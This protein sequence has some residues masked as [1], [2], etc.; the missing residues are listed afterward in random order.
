L[1]KSKE[2]WMIKNYCV[3]YGIRSTYDPANYFE[4]LHEP[5][6]VN[7]TRLFDYYFKHLSNVKVTN[8]GFDSTYYHTA[9]DQADRGYTIGEAI[10]ALDIT[11]FD[12]YAEQKKCLEQII[13]KCF[14]KNIRVIL[15]TPPVYKTF[16]TPSDTLELNTSIRTCQLMQSGYSNVAYFNLLN[17]SSFTGN[18]YFDRSHLNDAGA[19]KLSL[20]MNG[21][22]END[23][24]IRTK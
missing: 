15:F 19:K 22:I 21:L 24:L 7:R 20:K 4:V 3:Y 11:N 10:R 14:R 16:C 6:S 23:K 13:E 9:E 2:A 5:F 8:T 1:E 12:L 18:D 17:D